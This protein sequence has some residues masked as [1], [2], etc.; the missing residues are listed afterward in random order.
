[1]RGHSFS[2]RSLHEYTHA[3]HTWQQ[4][5]WRMQYNRQGMGLILFPK[6]VSLSPESFF[7]ILSPPHHSQLTVVAWA[8][9]VEWKL[10]HST[11]WKR[12][13]CVSHRNSEWD[14]KGWLS[15][16]D[17]QMKGL[18]TIDIS[19]LRCSLCIYEGWKDSKGNERGTERIEQ[20]ERL[21]LTFLRGKKNPKFTSWDAKK[22]D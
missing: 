5:Q 13:Q 11:K 7:F 16:K 10:K 2:L 20:I 1:M 12:V 6:R 4:H 22:N 9:N 18:R 3:L 17:T 8:C 19:S 15:W 14:P 21:L